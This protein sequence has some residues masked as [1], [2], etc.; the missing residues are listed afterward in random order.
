MVTPHRP[1]VIMAAFVDDY[2]QH[3]Q[4]LFAQE[5]NARSL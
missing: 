4:R 3:Y 5:K 1:P 2:C